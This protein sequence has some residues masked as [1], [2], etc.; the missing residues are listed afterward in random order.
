MGLLLGRT[1]IG[2]QEGDGTPQLFIPAMMDLYRA[3]RFPF[4]KLVTTYRFD[5]LNEAIED[6]K[7]GAAVNAV[8]R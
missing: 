8:L 2:A 5:Q 1:I 7:S 4:D 6:T 3:D